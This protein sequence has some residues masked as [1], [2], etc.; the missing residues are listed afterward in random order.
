MLAL[1]ANPDVAAIARMSV[2]SQR[3]G[4][5]RVQA[6]TGQ[7][8]GSA[9]VVI[10]ASTWTGESQY[11]GTG[12]VG[13]G[14]G[15]SAT[16]SIP[17]GPSRPVL[18]VFDLKPGSTAVT[19]FRSG[20][21]VLGVVRSG[22]IGAQGVSSASGALLPVTVQVTLP[23]SAATITATTTASGNDTARL[24]AVMIEPL[25]SRY[26]LGSD[27]Q[28]TALLRSASRI[29]ENTTVAVPGRGAAVIYA[30][31][32]SGHLARSYVSYDA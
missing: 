1:D 9:A 8:A 23:A 10:P 14:D 32:S 20:S 19:T 24:D 11:G 7:L 31:D 28:T 21:R 13:L 12:Y 30:H 15:G 2:V 4:S 26:L 27:D 3:I 22:D 6:E 25:V 5:R 17:D 18:P 29:T 16:L